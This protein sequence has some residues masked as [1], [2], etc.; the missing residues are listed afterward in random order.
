[1]GSAAPSAR[2]HDGNSETP[3]SRACIRL[4]RVIG[5]Y[6]LYSTYM[7]LVK[8][9]EWMITAQLCSLT[10]LT[11]TRHI[12]QQSLYHLHYGESPCTL[13]HGHTSTGV[14]HHAGLFTERDGRQGTR[15][16]KMH[17]TR[18]KQLHNKPC[19][20]CTPLRS[21]IVTGAEAGNRLSDNKNMSSMD[22]GLSSVMRP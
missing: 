13:S 18:R 10:R 2:G 12:Y 8:G 15:S 1:M 14:H 5:M 11:T 21:Q 20:H 4:F 22:P 19:A 7:Y 6:T 17:L 3:C 9:D 16:I